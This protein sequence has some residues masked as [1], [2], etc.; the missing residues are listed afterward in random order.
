VRWVMR[1]DEPP[2]L[3]E[4]ATEQRFGRYF[5]RELGTWDGRF[6]R[7]ERGAGDAVVTRLENERIDVELRDTSEPALVALGMGYYPRWQATHEKLGLLPV[8]AHPTVPGGKLSVPA[9]WL[10]PGRTT[11]RPSGALP[12][13]GKGRIIALFAALIAF[14]S[15][16]VARHAP[17]RRVVLR[18]LALGLRALRRRRGDIALAAWVALGLVV[19]GAGLASARSTAAAL[20]L[21]S[22]LRGTATVEA[23]TAGG[24]FRECAYSAWYGGYRC[25]RGL[26][27]QD[28][29]VDLLE[30]APPS[31]PFSVPAI[32]VSV[33]NRDTEVKIRFS[34]RLA[35]E[36]WATAT[37]NTRLT[38]PEGS[39]L[40][41][42]TQRTLR[43]EPRAEPRELTLL[44]SVAA[45][46]SVRIAVARRDHLEPERG[47]PRAPATSPH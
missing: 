34:A 29:V 35:G 2:S 16:A 43:F 21:G 26:L 25:A 22:A 17:A 8:Y 1:R 3:G 37:A 20:E 46:Q 14:G 40:L 45:G 13:D 18:R 44:T 31:P 30:D 36:Y 27:V 39:H 32:V 15:V 28:S 38:T 23:R 47:Y 11:F 19:L 42:G 7:V 9:A 33:T 10:P 6:A 4:P 5:V 12:S 24:A 41:D